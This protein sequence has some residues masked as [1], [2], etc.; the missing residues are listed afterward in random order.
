MQETFIS[1]IDHEFCKKC[2]RD[3]F[4]YRSVSDVGHLF[5]QRLLNYCPIG[6]ICLKQ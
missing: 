1:S 5:G 4:E 3:F 2:R 6:N